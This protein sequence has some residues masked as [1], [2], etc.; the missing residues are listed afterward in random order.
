MRSYLNILGL[1]TGNL[2]GIGSNLINY[3]INDDVHYLSIVLEAES[4]EV[5]YELSEKIM[6]QCV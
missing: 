1:K 6:N 5:C 4:R 3:W 2:V